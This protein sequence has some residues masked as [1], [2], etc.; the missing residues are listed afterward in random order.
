MKSIRLLL[1]SI[2]VLFAFSGQAFSQPKFVLHLTGGLS[3]PLPDLKGD[4]TTTATLIAPKT[5]ENYLMRL[6]VNFGADVKYAFDKKG[7]IRGVFGIGYNLMMN[8]ADIIGAPST[9]KFRPTIGILTLSL[10]PEYAFLPKGKFNP[11]VGVDFTANF[12]NG[13]FDY[14]PEYSPIFTNFSIESATRFGLQ[15][16]I[17]GDIVLGKN[18]GLVVGFKYCLANLIGKDSDTTK[19]SGTKRAL[20]DAEYTNQGTTFKAKNISY[21]QVYTGLAFF[22]GQPKKVVKK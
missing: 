15:F 13:S 18:I 6:G 21:V 10:G 19:L 5:D 8:P 2:I 1:V 17:G 7:N 9:I 3:V 22:F 11:F 14:E 4:I 12:I 20:N 16:G